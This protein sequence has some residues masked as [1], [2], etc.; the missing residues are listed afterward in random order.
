MFIGTII[1]DDKIVC[2]HNDVGNHELTFWNWQEGHSIP[3]STLGFIFYSS[4]LSYA[5]NC[6][7]LSFA[8][9]RQFYKPMNPFFGI[10]TVYYHIGIYVVVIGLALTAGFVGSYGPVSPMHICVPGPSDQ[11]T[12]MLYMCIPMTLSLLFA[13]ICALGSIYFISTRIRSNKKST[14]TKKME[15]LLLRF[16]AYCIGVIVA[17]SLIVACVWYFWSIQPDLE[18][19]LETTIKCEIQRYYI[20]SL[21]ECEVQ[22]RVHPFWFMA[23]IFSSILGTLAQLVSCDISICIYTIYYRNTN[24]YTNIL[25]KNEIRY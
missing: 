12:L 3:C 24:I 25:C 16:T 6:V 8:I 5:F 9:F 23:W 20:P 13:V 17:F 4:L 7:V 14:D 22:K 10:K 11:L 19:S 15:D 21:P 1:G 18:K 2:V